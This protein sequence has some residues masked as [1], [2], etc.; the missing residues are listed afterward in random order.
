VTS[1][2]D[3]RGSAL[4]EFSWLG[5]LLL[6][7][8]LWIVLSVFQ[9][10]RGAFGVSAAARAAARAY[11]LAPDD[12]TG[13]VRARQAARLALADQGAVGVAPDVRVTCTPYP[14]YCHQGTSVITVSVHSRVVLPLVPS[15]LGGN[16]PSFSLDATQTVPIGQFQEVGGG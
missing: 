10:Q 12:E 15:A 8:V 5:I 11:S 7:P 16:R 14:S 3:Q 1:P 2:R 13:L 9:V 6:L 4:V